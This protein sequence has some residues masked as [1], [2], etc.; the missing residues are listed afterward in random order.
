M[1]FTAIRAPLPWLAM[2]AGRLLAGR[3][4]GRHL[5]RLPRSLSITRDGKWF[6][7]ILLLIGVAAINTGNNLLYL[8]VATLLSLII[9]SGV[10]SEA[11]LRGLRAARVMPQL[12]FKG[13]PAPARLSITNTKKLLPSFSF[14]VTEAGQEAL[15]A[16]FLKLRA[17][18]TAH[19]HI[20]YT[21]QRRGIARLE[22]LRITTRF[23]F[24][25]FLKG[26]D[27][28]IGDELLV[29]PSIDPKLAMKAEVALSQGLAGSPKKGHGT[30]FH[31]LRDYTLEDDARH[32][33]W[34]S[35]ARGER[36]LLKEFESESD[37]KITIEFDNYQ[38]GNEEF[39]LLVDRAAATAAL[40]LE[41]GWSVG[42][43][44]LSG[45]LIPAIGREQLLLILR[46]LAVVCPAPGSGPPSVRVQ[47]L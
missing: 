12:A 42:L 5:F 33:H 32:I 36:L 29:L 22:R 38:G 13:A 26:R 14:K 30:E 18:E 9:V 46:E 10:M 35:A 24:G 7:G 39:E 16:Y 31:G 44:T 15:P 17:G 3:R 21:F 2:A 1:S 43:K 40:Y 45:R 19:K 37:R 8:I 4:G 11:T 47:G 25:L 34:R 28:H 6:I 27:E 23:P 41:K 20:E